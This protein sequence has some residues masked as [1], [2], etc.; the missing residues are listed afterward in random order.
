MTSAPSD[1]VVL[2]CDGSYP[3]PDGAA[4]GYL[5]RAG[6]TTVW[7]DAGS[8]TFANLQ[9]H[10]DPADLGAIVLSH[11]H[12]DHWSD[13]ESF[14]VWTLVQHPDRPVPVYAPPGLRARSYFSEKAGLDWHVIEDGDQVTIGD[15]GCTFS[16]TDHGPVTL[17]ARFDVTDGDRSRGS[18]AYSADTGPGWSL[19]ALGA[20]IGTALC[21][22]TYTADLERDFYHH[23]SGR[24][25]GAMA[26]DAGVGSLICTHRWPS[27]TAA[28][29]EAEASVAFGAPVRQAAIGSVFEW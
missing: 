7:L 17:A 19:D 4:S 14:A 11:E 1:L 16:A 28:A 29:L 25:A 23:L 9:R 15:L 26:R 10:I 27:V 22:A 18:L 21:E 2:G 13:L 24:Q 20:G 12:P 6:G 8:G 5:V 3:G